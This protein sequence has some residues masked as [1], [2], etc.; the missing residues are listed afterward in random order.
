[1]K[2]RKTVKP[3]HFNY[4]SDTGKSLR[5]SHTVAFLG[6]SEEHATVEQTVSPVHLLCQRCRWATVNCHAGVVP[7]DAILLM[8]YLFADGFQMGMNLSA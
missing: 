7:A 2:E 6:F 8:E 4:M 1:M 3:F 5:S